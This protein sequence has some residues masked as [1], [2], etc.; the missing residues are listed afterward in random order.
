MS[1]LCK[2][3]RK[4]KVNEDFGLKDNGTQYK[5]CIQCRNKKIKKI[6]EKEE[7]ITCCDVELIRDTFRK[8]NCRIVYLNDLKYM[9]DLDKHVVISI[10]S[11]MVIYN[12]IAIIETI[13]SDNFCPLMNLLSHLDIFKIGEEINMYGINLVIYKNSKDTMLRTTT[14]SANN[15]FEGFMKCI[16]LPNK[17]MC[18]IC[19]NKKKCF[20][21]CAKCK[22][23]LCVECFKKHNK[24]YVNSC[25][26]C[27]YNMSDRCYESNLVLN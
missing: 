9:M 4:T 19:N 27:R 3:C 21:E 12:N 22:N 1:V 25:P 8:L 13:T 26:Y 7:E 10:F 18:D 16:K 17:K 2:G 11:K 14:G 6:E 15:I 5:T 20:R 23:K 24:D